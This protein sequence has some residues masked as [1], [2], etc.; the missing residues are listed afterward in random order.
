MF[1]ILPALQLCLCRYLL[2]SGIHVLLR[3][4][5]NPDDRGP[6]YKTTGQGNIP[7]PDKSFLL[8]QDDQLLMSFSD[9]SFQL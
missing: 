6:G 5:Q 2:L 3:S 9:S 1:G 4:A 7:C 8:R